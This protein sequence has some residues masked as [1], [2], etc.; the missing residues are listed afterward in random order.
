M[1]A[2]NQRQAMRCQ[3]IVPYRN[4]CKIPNPTER[5]KATPSACA[6]MPAIVYIEALRKLRSATHSEAYEPYQSTPEGLEQHGIRRS[7]QQ[8]DKKYHQSSHNKAPYSKNRLNGP[9]HMATSQQAFRIP[10]SEIETRLSVQA[11]TSSA[12]QIDESSMMGGS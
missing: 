1:S 3:Q 9:Q 10:F 5:P 8:I 6:E 11:T 7:G 4:G 2:A 12:E